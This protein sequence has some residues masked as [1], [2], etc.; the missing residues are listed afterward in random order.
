[1]SSV[2]SREHIHSLYTEQ[3]VGYLLRAALISLSEPLVDDMLFSY[4]TRVRGR[5]QRHR[6]AAP[7]VPF[8]TI[9]VTP[10]NISWWNTEL[11]KGWGLGQIQSGNWDTDERSRRLEENKTRHGL[12]QRFIEG[13]EWEDTVYVRQAAEQI[14]E[15]GSFWGYQSLSEFKTQRCTYVD[16][17]YESIRENGYVPGKRHDVPDIDVRQNTQKYRHRLE[18]FVSIGRGGR[19]FYVDGIHRFVIAE[20][21][22]IE[23]PVHVLARHARWQQIRDEVATARESGELA[24]E[25]RDKT[26]HPDLDAIE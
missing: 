4:L 5:I 8:E 22:D 24:A 13:R 11:L 1:M 26:P 10:R 17:L 15:C 14:N 3:G 2:R 6:Y 16:E 20:I 7:P 25:I 23:I 12:R 18:P 9:E 19:L 21:L